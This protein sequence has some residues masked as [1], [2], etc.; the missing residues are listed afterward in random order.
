MNEDFLQYLW[1]FQK[2]NT[3][4]L[5]TTAGIPV[6][7]LQ[8]GRHNTDAGPDFLD[9]RIRIGD[10][11]WAGNVEIH[12]SASDW[13]RHGH[14]SDHGYDNVVL[15]VVYSADADIVTA[16]GMHIPMVCIRDLFDYQ[17]YRYYK[18]W[19]KQDGFI[20]CEALVPQVSTLTKT[21]MVHAAAVER[22]KQKSAICRDHLQQTQGDVEGSF[23]R[24]LLRS[25]GHKVNAIPFEQLALAVPHPL[26]RKV[27][28]D[29]AD[30]EA[31]LLGQAGMLQH[32]VHHPY[33]EDLSKRFAFLSAKYELKP[34]QASAWKLL[35]LRPQNFPA[36]RIAQ[37]AALYSRHESLADRV[38][39]AHSLHELNALF[40]AEPRDPFWRKHYTLSKES[41]EAPKSI[42]QDAIQ[43]IIINA[44]VPFY[45]AMAHYNRE[46]RWQQKATTLLESMPPETNRITTRYASFGF[47]LWNALDSQG[48]LHLKATWCESKKCLHCKVGINLMNH[49]EKYRDAHQKLL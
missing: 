22:L 44:V 12:L 26:L 24:L 1:K 48:L 9:A 4:H 35:R 41:S 38:L 27:R 14:Q 32:T 49:Y 19:V 28:H 45:F 16:S 17:D 7:V 6:Q 8:P 43:L 15:H 10:T 25:F 37:L 46:E 2:F 30:L 34:M 36:V 47:P 21:A 29:P 20:A 3:I 11:L 18:S 42:G 13:N 31:L 5:K 39:E 23:Y 40:A 33:T